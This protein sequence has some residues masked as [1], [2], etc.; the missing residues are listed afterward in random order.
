M[1]QVLSCKVIDRIFKYR[2]SG[3]FIR[4]FLSFFGMLLS[5]K[6]PMRKLGKT[7]GSFWMRHKTENTAVMTRYPSD[8]FKGPIWIRLETEMIRYFAF[9]ICESYRITFFQQSNLVFPGVIFTLSVSYR[10]G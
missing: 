3:T 4:N 6:R 9:R 7:D 10:N 5:Q 8:V 2:K 1:R